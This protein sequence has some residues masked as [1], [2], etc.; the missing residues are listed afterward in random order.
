MGMRLQK[1][2]GRQLMAAKKSRRATRP[3]FKVE[4]VYAEDGEPHSL[5]LLADLVLEEILRQRQATAASAGEETPPTAAEG[6]VH[7][8]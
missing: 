3:V 8:R 7:S 2:K 4:L 1:P 6:S 5:G